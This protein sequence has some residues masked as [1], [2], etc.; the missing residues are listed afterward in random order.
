MSEKLNNE[1]KVVH[2]WRLCNG[3]MKKK[4]G[5]LKKKVDYDK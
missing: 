1:K 3:L 5:G 2:I 4:R